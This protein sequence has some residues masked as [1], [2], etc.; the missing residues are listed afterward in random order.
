MQYR[1]HFKLFNP[2][3]CLVPDKPFTELPSIL[4]RC[5]ML[6]QERN[7]DQ[8]TD[9]AL[10]IDWAISEYFREIREKEISR[11]ENSFRPSED[12]RDDF[13]VWDGGTLANGRYIFN[14]LKESELEIVT[15]ENTKLFDALVGS[16]IYWDDMGG[17]SVSNLKNYELFAILS[18]WLLVDTL[19]YLDYNFVK[20]IDI[21]VSNCTRDNK[22]YRDFYSRLCQIQRSIYGNDIKYYFERS[23]NFAIEAMEAICHAEH[24]FLLEK[25]AVKIKETYKIEL[26]VEEKRRRSIL[27]EKLNIARHHKTNETKFS[28]IDEWIKEPSKFLSAEKAGI[29]FSEWLRKKGIEYEPRTIAGWIRACATKNN[30]TLR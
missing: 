7:L 15:I 18:M 3:K 13:F 26:Q 14:D 1:D 25:E 21:M 22:E 27:S 23:A 19:K 2:F 9:V 6:L 29:Y 28:V 10:N 16:I 17:D 4:Y 11:L 8:I 24:L 5:R 20:N 12:E 30:I